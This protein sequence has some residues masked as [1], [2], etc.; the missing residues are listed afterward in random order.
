L[1]DVK[2]I[3]RQVKEETTLF[4]EDIADLRND[5]KREG[6]RI[7]RFAM[8]VKNLFAKAGALKTA[9]SRSKKKQQK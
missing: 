7:E 5:I 3:T 8:F 9:G 6:F 2:D 4:R 1:S